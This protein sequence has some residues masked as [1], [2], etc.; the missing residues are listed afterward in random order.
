MDAGG[1]Y[2]VDNRD[3]TY[4]LVKLLVVDP[5]AVHVCVYKER[6]PSRPTVADIES[7]KPGLMG[8][9]NGIG[10]GHIPLSYGSF[11]EWRPKLITLSEVSDEELEGY[12][13]WEA[14]GG[15]VF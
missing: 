15:G 9:L 14:Q 3:G 11:A 7:L 8:D 2:S 12:K 10:M 5:I 1:I 6:F 13:I 4:S